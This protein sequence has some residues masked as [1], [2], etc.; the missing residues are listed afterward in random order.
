M[1]DDPRPLRPGRYYS[2]RELAEHALRAVDRVCGRGRR[3]FPSRAAL[4]D[5]LGVTA[6][7]LSAALALGDPDRPAVEY[8]RGHSVRR[9]ILRRLLGF[10]VQDEPR[11]GIDEAPEGERLTMPDPDA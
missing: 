8:S 3:P 2:E 11:F 10:A 9:L 6:P 4:A 7:A 1:P 5:A